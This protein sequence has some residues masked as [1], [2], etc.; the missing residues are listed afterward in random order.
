VL[1]GKSWTLDF[2]VQNGVK[3][4]DGTMKGPRHDH[5]IWDATTL[6]GTETSSFAA[7]LCES[8]APASSGTGPFTLIKT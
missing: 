5:Y 7:G 4:G 6:K 3:C 1:Y 8:T 2:D